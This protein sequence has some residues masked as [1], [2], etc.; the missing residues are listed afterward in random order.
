MLYSVLVG[1][2]GQER[3]VPVALCF[4]DRCL[5]GLSTNHMGNIF[6]FPVKTAVEN[7]HYNKQ[8]SD[9]KF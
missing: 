6:A 3:L 9:D 2:L 4:K 5:L 7:P 8:E 1:G